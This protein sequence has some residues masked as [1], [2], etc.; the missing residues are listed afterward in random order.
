MALSLQFRPCRNR[1]LLD[2]PLE[3]NGYFNQSVRDLLAD[4]IFRLSALKNGQRRSTL[5]MAGIV[6]PSIFL[7]GC[8]VA[9][10]QGSPNSITGSTGILPMS[11]ARQTV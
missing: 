11:A 8:L 9:G 7:V 10:P 6:F 4:F 2:G 1:V 3:I 5:E